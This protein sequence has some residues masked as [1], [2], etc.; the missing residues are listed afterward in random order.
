MCNKKDCVIQYVKQLGSE[1][2][3]CGMREAFRA[4][5][6]KR[7]FVAMSS[8]EIVLRTITDKDRRRGGVY[9]EDNFDDGW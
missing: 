3:V 7:G 2:I 6:G 5:D 1:K 9:G 8:R 4:T